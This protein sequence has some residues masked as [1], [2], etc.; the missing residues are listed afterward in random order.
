M[1]A[2]AREI[3]PTQTW[4]QLAA[5]GASITVAPSTLVTVQAPTAVSAD[6]RAAIAWRVDAMRAQVHAAA[7]MGGRLPTLVAV[8]GLAL[9]LTPPVVWRGYAE[10]YGRRVWQERTAQRPRS[11]LCPSCGEET[12]R[13]QTG[14]CMLCIAARVGALRAE[15]VLGPPSSWTPPPPRDPVA[16]RAGLYA[17]I[18]RADPLPPPPRR[19]AWVCET[20]GAPNVARRDVEGCGRCEL[21]AADVISL[22]KLGGGEDEEAVFE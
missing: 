18:A 9:P 21:R 14:D 7:R 11:G 20:C 2:A 1:S 15:G 10:V 22:A 3:V 13:N 19:A 16:W 5:R 8:P 12:E 17:E 4:R 6:L